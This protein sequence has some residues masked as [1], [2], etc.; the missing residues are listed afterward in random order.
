VAD[1]LLTLPADFPGL[2][3]EAERLALERFEALVSV[4][5]G[6]VAPWETHRPGIHEIEIGAMVALLRDITRLESQCW[7]SLWLCRR[8]GGMQA[9]LPVDQLSH[10]D[11]RA[12]I[13]TACHVAGM[14][15]P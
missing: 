12:L 3:E 10:A 5:H 1:P 7:L 8:Q 15:S 14:E 4:A 6:F 13:L 9:V 11:A 2:R